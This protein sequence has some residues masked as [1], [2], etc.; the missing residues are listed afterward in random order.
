M[1]NKTTIIGMAGIFVVCMGYWFFL[2]HYVYPKHPEWNFNGTPSP[3][4]QASTGDSSTQ[5]SVASTSNSSL[6]AATGVSSMVATTQEAMAETTQAISQTSLSATTQPGLAEI[7][8]GSSGIA[9]IG[10]T[11]PPVNSNDPG[12]VLGM[13]INPNGA[14]IGSVTLN[15]YKNDDANGLYVYQQPVEDYHLVSLGTRG[16]CE[17]AEFGCER[18]GVAT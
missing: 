6:I 4:S 14:A 5:P 10:S 18:S 17:R 11:N 12:Y 15:S 9:A 8:G 1:G 3:S 13:Q 16:D 2:V 7:S